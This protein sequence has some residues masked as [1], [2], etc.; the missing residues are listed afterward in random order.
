MPGPSGLTPKSLSLALPSVQQPDILP[1]SM[2]QLIDIK[3]FLITARTGSFAAAGRELD[4]TPSVLTKRVDRLEQVI[5]VR[6]FSRTTRRLTLTSEGERLRPRLQSLMGDLEHAL[7]DAQAS[8][9]QVRGHIRVKSPTTVRAE[10]GC[11]LARFGVANPNVTIELM[12]IDRAVNPLEENFD[13]ALGAMPTSFATVVDIPL[14]PYDRLLVATPDYLMRG[15]QLRH[16]A[17]L[18]LYECLVFL[19]AGPTWSFETGRGAVVV[20]V[21]ARFAS[22][23]SQVLHKAALSGLGLTILPRF[24]AAPDLAA[25]RLQAVLDDFPLTPFWFKAMVPANK[26][27][28]PV[29]AALLEHLKTEFGS[30]PPWDRQGRVDV[31]SEQTPSPAT[32]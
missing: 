13:V 25:G 27:R 30:V 31:M 15:P 12:L 3:A 29:V 23:D 4:V 20:D 18:V 8:D 17:D 10:V 9:H 22:N 6:L 16:P 14:C 1:A 28:N 2:A 11:A 5:G 21:R 7:R 32:A 19:P 26:V 24:L